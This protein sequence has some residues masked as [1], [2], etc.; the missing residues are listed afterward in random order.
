[1]LTTV[2][3]LFTLSVT[4]ETVST[5]IL[6][7][8]SPPR[9]VNSIHDNTIPRIQLNS[10]FFWIQ[11]FSNY[12]QLAGMVNVMIGKLN[13]PFFIVI[14]CNLE[15]IRKCTFKNRTIY[16]FSIC[17]HRSIRDLL[18]KCAR[19]V[20]LSQHLFAWQL[21]TRARY[22]TGTIQTLYRCATCWLY[23][24]MCTYAPNCEIVT[25][26]SFFRDFGFLVTCHEVHN[27][28]RKTH[29]SERFECF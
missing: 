22:T 10:E 5:R 17:S 7:T 9:S 14:E 6:A 18:N 4:R 29:C 28:K 25:E 3:V 19:Q 23:S 15:P 24:V 26:N 16:R 13:F 11:S 1:M 21:G 8:T 20:T 2:F 12:Y 27:V